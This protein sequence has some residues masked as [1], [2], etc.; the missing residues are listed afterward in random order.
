MIVTFENA[1]HSTFISLSQLVNQK[2]QVIPLAGK[3][4][5]FEQQMQVCRGT[6]GTPQKPCAASCKNLIFGFLP[7]FYSDKNKLWSAALLPKL[8]LVF[9]DFQ[10]S[11]LSFYARPWAS[12]MHSKFQKNFA[13]LQS[14]NTK[15]TSFCSSNYTREIP[16][17][18]HF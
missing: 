12:L 18:V 2:S 10:Q 13:C 16:I 8:L 5:L 6:Q 15:R 17:Q 3:V 11:L 1:F 9:V 7:S 14:S 4:D